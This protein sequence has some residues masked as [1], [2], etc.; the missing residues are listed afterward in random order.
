MADSIMTQTPRPLRLAVAGLTHETN[1]Y[2]VES[3]GPTPLSAFR[4]CAGDAIPARFTGAN[5]ALGGFIDGAAQAGAALA[6]TY[7][8]QATPSATIEA[9][10]YTHMKRTLLEAVGAVLP[11]DGV[12]LALHGAGVAEG[13]DDIEGD[14]LGALRERLGPDTPIAVVYD[15]HGNMT[16]AMRAGGDLTLPC[17]LYP[18][19]DLH[20]RGVAAVQRL[21]QTIR[22]ELRPVTRMREVPMLSYLVGT[23]AGTIAEQ[24]NQVCRQVAARENLVECA[25]FHGFPYADIAMPCPVVV[26][27]ADND[28]ERAQRC[29]DEIAQW[30]WDHRQAFLPHIVAPANAVRQALADTRHPVV[31]NERSDNPGGGTPGDAT[32]LL[33]AMLDAK[34]PAGTC[35]FAF[36]NDPATVAQAVQAGVG[37]TIAVSLGGK[38]GPFQGPP[39][40]AQAYVKAITDGGIVNRPDSAFGGVAFNLGTMC[41]L[42]I[43]GVDV[44]VASCAQ[45]TFDEE[46]FLL[47]GVDVR[48]RQVVALKG[49]NHF[50]AGFASIAAHIIPVD[51]D[52]LSTTDAARFPRRRLGRPCWPLAPETTFDTGPA[53]ARS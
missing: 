21:I 14:L 37:A 38:L 34:P 39:I 11:V 30:I 17:T 36:I 52:G 25:W 22:G 35:C 8:A 32:H 6:Y 4:Q 12:L 31:L 1:T 18:H 50:R 53:P 24:V 46:P 2:A 29:A 15:L 19:T 49:A 13:V 43:D 7:F 45:Q 42:Q 27:T 51:A 5:H 26:C 9:S 10:A 33:R 48:Q 28:A 16:E 20:E 47:N 40:A 23:Q 3:T 41:R 44:I